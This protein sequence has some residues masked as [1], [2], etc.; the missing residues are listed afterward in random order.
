MLSS[1]T[2]F[3][4]LCIWKLFPLQF[5]KSHFEPLCS[6]RPT[7]NVWI[8]AMKKLPQSYKTWEKYFSKSRN[9][10][11]AFVRVQMIRTRC[12]SW[13]WKRE[14]SLNIFTAELGISTCER[15]KLY[16]LPVSKTSKS[17]GAANDRPMH[18]WV[19]QLADAANYPKKRIQCRQTIKQE[20]HVQLVLSQKR[21][22]TR[23]IGCTAFDI[24]TT[25]WFFLLVFHGKSFMWSCIG[26]QWREEHP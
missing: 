8:N 16:V 14:N 10:T 3:K 11:C 7:R 26:F 2:V 19:P 6:S 20:K 17:T 24:C 1:T 18:V 21:N 13:L 9:I 23:L 25:V 12:W 15:A 22:K 4:S 5:L